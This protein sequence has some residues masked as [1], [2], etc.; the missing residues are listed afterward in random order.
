[1]IYE[2]PYISAKILKIAKDMVADKCFKYVCSGSEIQRVYDKAYETYQVNEAKMLRYCIAPD[3]AVYITIRPKCQPFAVPIMGH[4]VCY[5]RVRKREKPM[6]ANTISNLAHIRYDDAGVSYTQTIEEHSRNV[7][8][9]AADML[10]GTGFVSCAKLAGL[11]HDMG[12]CQSKYQDYLSRAAAGE[13]VRR[14]SVNH[15]YAGCIYILERY[16]SAQDPFYQ[17]TSEIIASVIGGHHGLFDC[18]SVDGRENGFKKRLEKDRREIQYEAAKN[19]FLEHVADET[20]IEGLFAAAVEEIRT[21]FLTLP[22]Y[23]DWFCLS[24]VVRLI[25]S[26]VMAADHEDTRLFM[27]GEVKASETPHNWADD[28]SFF[29]EKIA[30]FKADTELNLVRQDISN[31]C[32]QAALNRLPGIYR[33]SV[34]TGGGKTLSAQRFALHHAH[35]HGKKRVIYVVPYLSILDQN[36]KTVREYTPSTTAVLEHHSNVVRD[37][38]SKEEL[39]KYDLLKQSWDSPII[40]TTMVQLLEVLFAHQSSRIARMQALVDSIIII[41]EV[42]ALPVKVTAMFSVALN[43]L[44]KYCNATVVLSSATQPSLDTVSG[45]EL[46]YAADADLVTLTPE[47]QTVFERANI[48]NEVDSC[49]KS[50]EGFVEYVLDKIERSPSTLV[51][52]NTKSEARE[53]FHSLR[54]NESSQEWDIYHLSTS[55]C[56]KHRM[57]VLEEIREKLSQVQQQQTERKVICVSTQLVEAGIDFSFKTVVRV[58]AGLDSIVQAAGRCNRSNEYGEKG[59][60]YVVGLANENLKMLEEIRHGQN[61]TKPILQCNPSSLTDPE[62]VSIYFRNYYKS[63]K[64]G[65]ILYNLNLNSNNFQMAELLGNSLDEYKHTLA[66]TD[67]RLKQPFKTV[68]EKFSVFDNKTY[69]IIVPYGDE[70]QALSAELLERGNTYDINKELAD[71]ISKARQYTVSLY[72]YQVQKLRDEKMLSDETLDGRVMVLSKQA[73]DDYE[74]VQPEAKHKAEDFIL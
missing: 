61:C 49:G 31:Q 47:Q 24:F 64:K 16:H 40:I 36:A 21:N 59:E 42:Q 27:M 20:E 18:L 25:Q 35:K 58:L 45:W 29:E 1:M 5:Y 70:G 44:Q 9:Y 32:K 53:L 67:Y 74:G 8:A 2:A 73:Y 60:V 66:A 46:E 41:D 69:D 15:T 55:M 63:Y 10:A 56:Q 48:N 33:L 43:A 4:G 54:E 51:I 19:Y 28:I 13:E 14:G 17:L 11:L 50:S 72:D 65:K 52:C 22:Y 38:M 71:L 3:R 62:I 26:A 23:K 68:A 12:K 37:D 39:T 30:N 57:D 34:G 7:S 6:K